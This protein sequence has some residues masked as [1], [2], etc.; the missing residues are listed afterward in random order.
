LIYYLQGAAE[1]SMGAHLLSKPA[2]EYGNDV[3]IHSYLNYNF[4]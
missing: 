1:L 2:D 3:S 4:T